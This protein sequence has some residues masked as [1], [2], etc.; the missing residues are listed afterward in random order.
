MMIYKS[1]INA[2]IMTLAGITLGA[3]AVCF[4]LL[5]AEQL[6]G[7]CLAISAVFC[8]IIGAD[9]FLDKKPYIALSEYGI[10]DLS[11]IREEIEWDAIL[12]VDDFF[13][14]GQDIVRLL[15]GSDYK[16]DLIRP[17]WFNRLDGFYRRQGLKALYIRTNGLDVKSAQLVAFIERM[18]KAGTDERSYLVERASL[19][20]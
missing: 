6:L 10:T 2:V 1:G 15:V 16:P 7:W 12:Y 13:Y 8:T 19:Y 5:T 11:V 3:A 20:L 14:R 18:V 4:L 17:S 9:S